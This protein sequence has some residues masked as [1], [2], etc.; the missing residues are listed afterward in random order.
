MHRFE[1]RM[2]RLVH[3]GG[4][5]RAV[6]LGFGDKARPQRVTGELRRGHAGLLREALDD[7]S[8]G[9]VTQ[10]C[11]THLRVT[12]NGPKHWAF[13]DT[14]QRQPVFGRT[15]GA[16]RWIAAVCDHFD[17]TFSLLI[18]FT[19]TYEGL[20]TFGDELE[21][22]HIERDELGATKAAGEPQEQQRAVSHTE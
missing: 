10:A 3:D 6:L 14:G 15:H 21:V 7:H 4:I 22:T 17:E 20:E 18:G 12:I 16:R 13:G 19:A 11:G 8:H 1:A 9:K 5:V 2:S